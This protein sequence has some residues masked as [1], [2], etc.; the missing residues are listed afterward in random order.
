MNKLFNL[1]LML[2]ICSTQIYAEPLTTNWERPFNE[3]ITSLRT[4]TWVPHRF[5]PTDLKNTSDTMWTLLKKKRNDW[6]DLLNFSTSLDI[7]TNL[8]KEF[9]KQKYIGKIFNTKAGTMVFTMKDFPNII[10]KIDNRPASEFEDGFFRSYYG[11]FLK[12]QMIQTNAFEGEFNMLF[13]PHEYGRDSQEAKVKVV[14][15]ETLPSFS[16][17]EIDH[18]VLLHQLI[19][20]AQTDSVIKTRLISLFEQMLTYICRVN[21]DDINFRNVPFTVDGRLAPFDTDSF[22]RRSGVNTFLRTFFAYKIISLEKATSIVEN[23]CEDH[24]KYIINNLGGVYT[25]PLLERNFN[26][27]D[28]TLRG[29]ISF[30]STKTLGASN[31]VDFIGL[32][33]TYGKIISA[34]LSAKINKFDQQSLLGKRC[35]LIHDAVDIAFNAIGDTSGTATSLLVKEIF[36]KARQAGKLYAS[37]PINSLGTSL[38][39]QL[40]DFICY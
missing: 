22:L 11:A 14:F 15:S 21:F 6:K 23:N 28:E 30:L 24:S 25:D 20:K 9:Q 27:N 33:A 26:Q 18:R 16:V 7:L 32:D 40:K 38:E 35:D 37:G 10:V 13:L 2:V 34:A 29:M 31:T 12:S 8:R 19:M 5:S 3:A 4:R 36:E 39:N 1:C 17:A